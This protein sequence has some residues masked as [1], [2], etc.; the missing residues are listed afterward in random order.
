M[1]EYTRGLVGVALFLHLYEQKDNWPRH[2]DIPVIRS[3]ASNM[4]PRQLKITDC[5]LLDRV[6]YIVYY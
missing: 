2:D 5:L 3:I 6:R 1:N 4:F